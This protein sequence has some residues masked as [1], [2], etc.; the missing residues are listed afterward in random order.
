MTF[1]AL[2]LTRFLNG[3]YRFLDIFDTIDA[4]E[5]PHTPP[6]AVRWLKPWLMADVAG[7]R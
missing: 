5:F 4:V 3:L 1:N 6:P 2:K 7:R